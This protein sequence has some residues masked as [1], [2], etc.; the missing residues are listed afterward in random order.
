VAHGKSSQLSSEESRSLALLEGDKVDSFI[1][2]ETLA[3]IFQSTCSIFPDKIAIISGKRTVTYKELD[4]LSTHVAAYLNAVGIGKGNVVGLFLPRGADLLIAQLGITKS[5]A[6]WLPFDSDTPHERI[7]VC[8]NASEAKALL[9]CEELARTLNGVVTK[10]LTFES[11]LAKELLAV[12]QHADSSDIAYII[13]TSGSTGA[14]KGISISHANICHFLRS[15]NA[16]LGILETD[17]VYQGFSCSFDMSFEE[18]WISYLVG[19]SIWVAP[20]A[21]ITDPEALAECLNRESITVLHAVPTLLSL[22][23]DPLKKLR[24]INVGGEACTQALATRLLNENLN[25]KLFNT[26]GPT[27]TTVSATVAELKLNETINIG[28]PLPNYGVIILNESKEVC[29]LNE[30]GEIAITGPGLSPGYLYNPKLTSDKFIFFK[31]PISQVSKRVYL[32]GDLGKIDEKGKVYCIGRIDNQV[33]L[34]GFRIEPDEISAAILKSDKIKNAAVVLRKYN[35]SDELVAFVV[36]TDGTLIEINELK[37]EVAKYVPKYM[38]P[39]HVEQLESLPRLVS[40]KID[41]KTLKLLELKQTNNY[42]NYTLK[43][44]NDEERVLFECIIQLVPSSCPHSESDFFDDIGGHSLL[45]ARL[46][47]LVR[48]DPRFVALSISTIYQKRKLGLIALVMAEIASKRIFT[49][50]EVKV[51]KSDHRRLVCGIAQA[52]VVPIFISLNILDWLAPFFTYHYFTGDEGDSI[53]NAI[54]LSLGA[55]VAFRLLNFVIA[56]LGK[57]FLTRPLQHGRYPLWGKE[58]FNWWLAT[59]FAELPD[60]Y[61]ITST[62]WIRV[63]LRALGAKIGK[64]AIIDT[65]TFSVP[66]LISIGDFVTIGNFANI[67]N[68]RIENGY[69]IVGKVI[70]EDEASI[71]SYS[72]L[73]EN[74]HVRKR[75]VLSGLSCLSANKIIDE[76]E[77]WEGSPACKVTKN[78]CTERL[79]IKVPGYKNLAITCIL[80]LSAVF[81]SLLFFIPTFPAF[82]AIDWIDSNWLDIFNSKYGQIITFLYIFFLSLPAS[83][84]FI[85]VT[86]I[87]AASIRRMLPKAVPQTYPINSRKF[88]RKKFL[89]Q[90]IDSSLRELH[91][92]YASVFVP[93]WLRM[94][95]AKIGSNS[96]IS[97]A[98]GFIP[99]LLELGDDCFIADGASIG[100]EEISSGWITESKTV[101][102]D[103]SFVGNNAYVAGGAKIPSDVL[104]GVQT[105]T[106]NNEILKSA[107]TWL[108]SPAVLLPSRASSPQF[109]EELTFRPSVE[110]FIARATIELLRILTPISFAIASGYSM[111]KLLLPIAIK[112]GLGFYFL[113]AL[114]AAGCVYAISCFLF[115]LCLK[116]IFIGRYKPRAAPMWTVFVWFSEAITSIYES[117]AVPNLIN[118]LRGTPLLPFLL[119]SLGVR[120]GKNVFI[121]TTDIT[122]FDCVKIGDRTELNNWCGP[123][124][125]LFEDRIMKIGNIEI[126]NDVCIGPRTIILYDTIIDDQ[127]KLGSLTL[128]SKGE[129]LPRCSKW[130]GSP[131]ISVNNSSF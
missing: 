31:D 19:A 55:F 49:K 36:T 57:R 51:D 26:Y 4:L 70:I 3:D 45:A 48:K 35:S 43:P 18:I 120:I 80:G 126:G 101:I 11:L 86:M 111:V 53:I 96:E 94:L 39:V 63:Y 46:V 114:S 123:Q 21:I 131:A 69:L 121:N 78:N 27:E 93:L 13:Y 99:E 122:E 107:Q 82:L 125:H 68:A 10:V 117:L 118:L 105:R 89:S 115:V 16:I 1:R 58:Y 112:Y 67:E 95:G 60:T 42:F 22:I 17:K 100:E 50:A 56:I 44:K 34:R 59:R 73:E 6:G 113:A 7:S 98:E 9:T 40:G 130:E 37:N 61:L 106:P 64:G 12:T 32:T 66:E 108:G 74:T 81:A 128:V 29:S 79:R 54:G 129:H 75:G 91:G 41:L 23:S 30:E 71:E 119:R 92:I 104:I 97:N 88:L 116:W 109:A 28:K 38:V 33:K 90:I 72:V 5:G 52:L 14:P 8:L 20:K 65:V 124:T 24:M 110:R 47:S 84:L 2:N 25:R 76:D 15:E 77:R 85:T 87:F 62:P 102:N 103:R 83:A 127:V